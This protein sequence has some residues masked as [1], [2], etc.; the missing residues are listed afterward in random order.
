MG[1]SPEFVSSQTFRLPN[2]VSLQTSGSESM[3]DGEAGKGLSVCMTH[4]LAI[5]RRP[6]LLLLRLNQLD[7]A[8]RS[9]ERDPCSGF[10]LLQSGFV[11]SHE[12]G[13]R[14]GVLNDG[15]LGESVIR[16]KFRCKKS[17]FAGRKS[18]TN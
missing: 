8:G 10:C 17:E 14:M 1:S 18:E 5:P 6:L 2:L 13:A 15:V 11:C 3:S 12:E 9:R 16:S 4:P 7:F